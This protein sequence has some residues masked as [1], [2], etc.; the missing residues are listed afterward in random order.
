M[1]SITTEEAS[2]GP[3]IVLPGDILPGPES[4]LLDDAPTA[5]V[6]KL[7]P[8]LQ[9]MDDDTIAA[10]KAG[11]LK[12][13]ATGNRWWVE[14]NQRRVSLYYLQKKSAGV[15]S[16]GEGRHTRAHVGRLVRNNAE[17]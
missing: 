1:A 2:S 4:G 14:S 16:G 12:H 8:G 5:P 9:P 13:A 10:V 17:D 15:M 6:I 3:K 11:V 7:G